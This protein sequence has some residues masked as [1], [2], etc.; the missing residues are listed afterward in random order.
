MVNQRLRE[1]DKLKDEILANTS[2]ELR[3]PLYGITGLAEALVAGSR[4]ELPEP[5]KKDLSMISA[6]GQR[7]ANLV[8]DIL[9]FSKVRDRKLELALEP[10]D[11]RSLTH[12]VLTLG[13]P[14]VGE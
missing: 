4:G 2:H 3:T 10:V 8:T 12:M 11:L 9:D 7:L 14:L 6:S 1:V 13:G 5:M